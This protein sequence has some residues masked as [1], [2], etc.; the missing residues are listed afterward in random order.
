M[1]YLHAYKI[2]V[3]LIDGVETEHTIGVV[4]R[5]DGSIDPKRSFA[6]FQ[7]EFNDRLKSM[8][9]YTVLYLSNPEVFYP[10]DKIM[11][12]KVIWS[13]SQEAEE[14][15]EIAKRN[16]GFLAQTSNA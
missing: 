4:R 5:P 11:R 6:K 2:V 7:Q 9:Q 15:E 3:G 8:Y 10:M 14:V 12:I 16:L 13:E 1:S